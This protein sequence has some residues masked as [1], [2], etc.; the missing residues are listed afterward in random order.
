MVQTSL[1][2]TACPPEPEDVI[3]VVPIHDVRSLLIQ[4]MGVACALAVMTRVKGS[5][6]L[7]LDQDPARGGVVCLFCFPSSGV[8]GT[9][10]PRHSWIS[11]RKW[12]LSLLLCFWFTLLFTRELMSNVCVFRCFSVLWRQSGEMLDATLSCC[13]L[14][15]EMQVKME[16]KSENVVDV[17]LTLLSMFSFQGCGLTGCL[18]PFQIPYLDT[19]LG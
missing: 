14:A 11:F 12:P 18:S 13:T 17:G 10:C 5:G 19:L 2:G 1:V 3:M 9:K 15:M 8:L 7:A 4:T 6:F 16:T